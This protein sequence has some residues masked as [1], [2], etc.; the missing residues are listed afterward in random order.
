M[1]KLLIV[2]AAGAFLASCSSSQD[3]EAAEGF[4]KCVDTSGAAEST[5]VT[6]LLES[7]EKTLTCVN[8]W[9]AK[10]KGKITKEGFRAELKK[11]CPE[12]HATAEQMGMFAE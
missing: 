3:K 4:C 8:D 12:A 10:F 6:E 11:A 7:N 1:K 2:F 9:Q 5:D